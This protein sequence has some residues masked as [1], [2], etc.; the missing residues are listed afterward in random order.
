MVR[1]PVLAEEGT[2]GIARH[3]G[4]VEWTGIGE[5]RSASPTASQPRSFLRAPSGATVPER[6]RAQGKPTSTPTQCGNSAPRSRA[7]AGCAAPE[8]PYVADEVVG[9]SRD[10]GSVDPSRFD[11][12][13]RRLLVR[14]LICGG[15]VIGAAIAYFLS[16]RGAQAIVI[17]RTEV[18]CAASASRAAFSRSIG[19][20]A[21]PRGP[22]ASQL[23]AARAPAGR[24]RRGLGLPPPRHVW[25][26]IGSGSTRSSRQSGVS[27]VSEKVTISQRL[28]S[29][30]S[31]AQVHPARFT[32]ALM[33]AAELGGAELRIGHVLGL[34]RD[35]SGESVVGLQVGGEELFGDA[36]VI[37]MGPWSILAAAWL[38][39]PPV[40]G[41][42][43]HSILFDTGTEC[44]RRRCSSSSVMPAARRPRP[45]FPEKRRHHLRL[46]PLQSEPAAGR[47]R[48]GGARSR[49][50]REAADPH[51]SLAGSR[52][53]CDPGTAG[54]L[55]ADNDGRA[56][57]IGRVKGVNG[58]Y[59]GTGHS[60]WGILN[61]PATGE[62]TPASAIA[63]NSHRRASR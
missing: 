4:P 39:L 63:M 55:P 15:G 1:L 61:A 41:L 62:V 25:R 26:V 60:I 28:G 30:Q 45:R 38:P 37:A 46:R 54:L 27:W 24:D 50:N 23:R 35:H 36:V 8:M 14:V 43:G 2:D 16:R 29:P 48:R 21:G 33:G 49:R 22:R 44:R 19:A 51:R 57:L 58:A 11:R 17:E 7:C 40:F 5:P 9:F 20:T 12:A 10:A 47:S 32:R 59:V 56:P 13:G 18:A 34:L 53:E 42:K 31:T 52:A 6:S 3:T